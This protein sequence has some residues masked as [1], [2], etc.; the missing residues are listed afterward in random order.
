MTK[1][2][3]FYIIGILEMQ[4][5]VTS[6]YKCNYFCNI[7]CVSLYFSEYI[8]VFHKSNMVEAGEMKACTAFAEY[9]GSTANAHVRLLTT[10]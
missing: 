7:L 3:F 4:L 8:Y 2:F 1:H 6:I 5:F 10:A 9:P